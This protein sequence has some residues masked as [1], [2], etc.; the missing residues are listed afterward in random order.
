VRQAVVASSAAP[1]RGTDTRRLLAVTIAALVL[2]TY[3]L[4]VGALWDRDETKYTQVAVEI[5]RTRDPF[6]LNFNGEPWFVHPPLFM[7][8][9]AATGWLLGFTEFTARIWSAVSGAAV[10]AVTFLLGRFLYDPRTGLLAS[11]ILATTMQVV[12]QS[13]LAVFD[14]TLLAFMIAAFYMFLVARTSGSRGASLWAWMWAG[15][16][17]TTKGPIGLLLPAMVLTTLALVQRRLAF[18]RWRDLPLLELAVFAVIGLHWYVIETVR[19]GLPFLRTVVGDY[20]VGRFFGVV[21]DQPGPWWYYGPVLVVG[22]FPWTGFVPSALVY[23]LRRRR[24]IASQ[25]TLLWIGITVAFYSAA[26]TKLPNYLLPVYPLL[27]IAI[28]KMCL[29]GLDRRTI[30]APRLL[31]WAFGLVPAGAAVFVAAIAVLGFIRHPADLVPLRTPLLIVAGVFVAG[32]LAAVGLYLTR[33]ERP[34]VLA[35]AA[36]IAVA[37]PVLVHYALPAIEPYRSL[38]RVAQRLAE[39]LR[40]H[41]GLAGVMPETPSLVYYTRHRVIWVE[42]PAD[43]DQA[44]CRYH[45]LFVVV[46]DDE[47]R[48]WVASRLP[49]AAREQGAD[50]PYRILLKEGATACSGALTNR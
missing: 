10:V 43:L 18:P 9:Q 33:R 6:T 27:A 44:V 2:F 32:P 25:V 24:E 36:T 21:Q 47:Y 41:D 26:G 48:A 35:L 4:G 8:L 30:D 46:P 19:H 37:L 39:Q 29:D 5:L 20:L 13:R 22:T 42:D 7:W 49:A 23:H 12:A 40:L 50:G 34:A 31:G 17:T 16:A 3:G 38:P 11:V 14:P 45:R 28:G 15:L 1:W